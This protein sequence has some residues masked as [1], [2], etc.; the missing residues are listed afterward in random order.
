MQANNFMSKAH[1]FKR[2]K[3]TRLIKTG[4]KIMALLIRLN[5]YRRNNFSD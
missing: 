3:K 5:K 1:M 4:F 2:R